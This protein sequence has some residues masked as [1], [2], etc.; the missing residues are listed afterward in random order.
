M[1]G[2][3]VGQ[4]T[5][6]VVDMQNDLLHPEG[7]LARRL[8]QKPAPMFDLDFLRGTIAPIGRLAEGFREVRRPVPY[9]AHV[10]KPDYSDAQFPYWRIRS[11]DPEYKFLVEGSFGARIV[12]ELSRGRASISS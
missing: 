6:I 11:A 1:N 12:E 8:R 2:A 5:L 3:D 9:L 7:A 10:L 4:S